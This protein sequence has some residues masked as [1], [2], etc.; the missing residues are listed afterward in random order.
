MLKRILRG[1]L[2]GLV[3]IGCTS[4]NGE[5]LD[6]ALNEAGENRQEIEMFLKT[7]SEDTGQKEAAE[8]MVAAMVGQFAMEGE[9][10]DSL[11]ALYRTLPQ[12]EITRFDSASLQKA[13]IY[14][15]FPLKKV[16]DLETLSSQYLS[17][18]FDDA[19]RR[20]QDRPW[21][22]DL[23]T[24]EY[25]ELL[26]PY[27][28]G[29]EKLTQWR[30]PYRNWL[31]GIEDSLSRCQNSVEA[32]RIVAMHIGTMPYNDQLSTPHRSAIDLLEWPVGYC[33]DDCDRTL[34]AM[35]AEGIPVAVDV[36]PVSPDNGG[37]HKWT[38]V[39]D[40]LDK[41]YRMFDNGS[42]LPT[43]DSIHYDQRKK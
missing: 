33:R 14:A 19:W 29:N 42:F 16:S 26:A 27:R 23:S 30:D 11:E 40:N 4:P 21:N 17:S 6:F 32:A 8:Y 34:Y 39:Y 22:K 37:S 38:V 36:M 25:C 15:S 31:A 10:M 13:R 18:N 35:R 41:T 2:I 28:V 43:R 3:A 9:G 7:H 5:L 24:E 1:L 20:R 12:K